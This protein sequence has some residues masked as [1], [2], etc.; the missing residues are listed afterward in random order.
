MGKSEQ[1]KNEN[2]QMNTIEIDGKEIEVPSAA[3]TKA[4]RSSSTYKD[5]KLSQADAE[6]LAK[7]LSGKGGAE[8]NLA[9]ADAL[10][11]D[12]SIPDA[13]RKQIAQAVKVVRAAV[14]SQAAK[15][16]AA[17]KAAKKADEDKKKAGDKLALVVAA[18][19]AKAGKVHESFVLGL[20]AMAGKKF[21]IDST[22]LTVNEGV[23][24]T[25]N[26][27]SAVVADLAHTTEVLD[28]M[29]ASTVWALGD[30]CLVLRQ[31]CAGDKSLNYEDVLAQIIRHT[32]KQKHTVMESI[33]LA[34]EFPH[35]ERMPSLTATHH[36][37]ILNYREGIS[38][39]RMAKI[40]SACLSG[41]E[42]EEIKTAS[43]EV[44]KQTRPWSCSRLRKELQEASGKPKKE[45]AAG[46]K[47]NAED[48]KPDEPAAAPEPQ[49]QA[50]AGYLFI[51]EEANVFQSDIPSPAAQF[52]G[53]FLVIDL[54]SMT[55]VNA[56]GSEGDRVLPLAEMWFD[57]P[58]EPVPAKK[59]GK[60]KAQAQEAPAPDADDIVV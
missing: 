58:P 59:K 28:K 40:I 46:P 26:D 32:G 6:M 11:D 16:E 25:A 1:K 12:D 55:T 33:R 44:I 57:A 3:F 22:G 10:N 24:L 56:D 41:E 18:G 35:D 27:I 8:K 9:K 39:P 2:N 43:G 42:G 54:G 45:G 19:Q 15:K 47:G 36:Q 37:E 49:G 21:S 53:K 20:S 29:K 38:K 4:I 30:A 51:D 31:V 60:Q 13:T 23:T 17:D 5:A 34:T 50:L 14:N 48:N 52:S 7:I